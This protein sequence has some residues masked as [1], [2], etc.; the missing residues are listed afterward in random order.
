M[1]MQLKIIGKEQKMI[2]SLKV[3]SHAIIVLLFLTMVI[4]EPSLFNFAYFVVLF[5]YMWKLKWL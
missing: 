2:T 4:F 1:I 3:V 5:Y